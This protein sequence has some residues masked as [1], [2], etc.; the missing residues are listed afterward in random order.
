M[1]Q[2]VVP[3][4]AQPS[5]HSQSFRLM[6]HPANTLKHASKIKLNNQAFSDSQSLGKNVSDKLYRFK[7]GRSQ[8]I[9]LD[10]QGRNKKG[11]FGVEL[12]SAKK[13]Q[14]SI[15]KEI[16]GS[17]FKGLSRKKIRP[18]LQKEFQSKYKKLSSKS[19][20]LDLDK[21]LYYLRFKRLKK[22]SSYTLTLA[23]DWGALN[24]NGTS[25]IST[26]VGFDLST[27]QPNANDLES[28]NAVTNDWFGT[29]L[30]DP[31]LATISRSRFADNTL[32]RSDMLTLFSSTLDDGKVDAI[33]FSDLQTLVA[34]HQQLG[35]PEHV[36][37]LADK[38]V[39]GTSAN[40]F[41]Q[42]S[43]L[44]DLAPGS[45]EEHLTA[46]V[47]KWFMGG[48]RPAA[49]AEYEM[50]YT[51]AGG[52]L[53][54][55]DNVPRLEDIR[56][57]YLADCYF[58]A[59][60]GANV[61][62]QPDVIRD[63]FIDNG[64]GTFTVKFYGQNNG[65]VV[66]EADY[67]TVDRWL[68]TNI[69]SSEHSDQQFA[70]FDEHDRGLWVAL[71]EKAYA[72][73]AESSLSFRPVPINSYDGIQYG[74]GFR[75]MA[76][77]S[78]QDGKTYTNLNYG[79]ADVGDFPGFETI[80]TLFQN[81]TPMVAST[82]SDPALGIVKDHQYVIVGMNAETQTLRL[83]NPQGTRSNPRPGEDSTGYRTIAYSDFAA[84]FDSVEF[85]RSAS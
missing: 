55:V 67:V 29:S 6:S 69:S 4:Y 2:Y 59:A 22:K 45:T 47:D 20:S 70:A 80:N 11:V 13:T 31:G 14:R 42:G 77:L 38:V 24:P 8:K 37:V 50:T 60:L 28:A 57:G 10:I 85:Q 39:N 72:Q 76:A 40:T 81:Q 7:L 32:D 65:K 41:Y 79:V 83:Y 30:R 68:P 16:G 56:Q 62:H 19:T 61:A 34:H 25:D 12:Y 54:G 21:G 48:D 9:S 53:F 18:Y 74:K 66:S 3:F 73:F 51:K 64:D 71:A 36:Y 78:G 63:M 15:L 82:V 49:P 44:G 23:K 27:F 75:A 46:L 33:E 84:N 26:P 1:Y 5:V 58:L 17:E 43:S 35:M 52:H